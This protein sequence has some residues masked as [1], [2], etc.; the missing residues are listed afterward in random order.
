MMWIGISC[1]GFVTANL[2]AYK[3][4]GATV[5]GILLVSVIS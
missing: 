3:I 5:A 2:L 4:K 1:G